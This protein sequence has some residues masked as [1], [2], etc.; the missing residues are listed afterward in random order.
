[1]IGQQAQVMAFAD[2]FLVLA[3]LFGAMVLLVPL[4]RAPRE[5]AGA[6]TH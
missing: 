2:V 3:L 5:G 1:M 4:V 6:P